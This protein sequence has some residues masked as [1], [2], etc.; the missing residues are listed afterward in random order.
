MPLPLTCEN[1]NLEHEEYEHASRVKS[2]IKEKKTDIM[3]VLETKL[4]KKKLEEV[5]QNK[6]NG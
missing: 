3:S 6:F 5:M 2:L 4:T 1:Y